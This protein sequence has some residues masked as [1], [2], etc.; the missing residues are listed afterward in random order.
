M[1]VVRTATTIYRGRNGAGEAREFS[2]GGERLIVPR[3]R[4][5]ERNVVCVYLFFRSVTGYA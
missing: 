1:K 2:R 3:A 4:A 5:C